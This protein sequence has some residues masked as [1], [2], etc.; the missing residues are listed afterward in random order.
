MLVK[1]KLLWAKVST[2]LFSIATIVVFPLLPLGI[3]AKKNA[4]HIKEENMLLTTAVLSV[5][6]FVTSEGNFCRAAYVLL[7]LYSICW[8]FGIDAAAGEPMKTTIENTYTG[9][10]TANSAFVALTAT[11]MIHSIERF[12]WHVVLNRRF[13]DWL[14]KG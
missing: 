3:E 12:N 6:F 14:E 8:E 13:P 7:F 1:L 10:M 4:Y 5:A 11:L 2:W 9:W